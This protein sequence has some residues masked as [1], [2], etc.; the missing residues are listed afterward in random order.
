[1]C[2]NWFRNS[3]KEVVWVL[4]LNSAES[5]WIIS[6]LPGQLHSDMEEYDAIFEFLE[7]HRYPTDYTKNQERCLRRKAQEH[8]QAR[9]GILYYSKEP[10][11]IE[12]S[13][14]WKNAP[15]S[16][17]NKERILKAYHDNNGQGKAAVVKINWLIV[18]WAYGLHHLVVTLEEIKLS[19]RLQR[20]FI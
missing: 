11:N 8:F 15:R 12:G 4:I 18:K 14:E 1:M 13:R 5:F 3:I 6:S 10:A 20:D 17:I 2:Q 9:N 7:N 19:G 16:L